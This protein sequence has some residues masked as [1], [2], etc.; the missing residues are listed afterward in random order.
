MLSL[1]K[2]I[3]ANPCLPVSSQQAHVRKK[4]YRFIVSQ[5]TVPESSSEDNSVDLTPTKKKSKKIMD[6]SSLS[7]ET[8]EAMRQE[9]LRLESM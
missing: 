3:V 6:D 5:R 1:Y 9:E 4:L 8:R 2:E 7:V